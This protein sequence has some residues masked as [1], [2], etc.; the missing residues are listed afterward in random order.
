VTPRIAYLADG[1]VH[2]KL[3][4]EPPRVVESPFIE[5]ARRRETSIVQ[6]NAW[7][8][9]GASALVAARGADPTGIVDLATIT[10]ISRGRAAEELLYV[11]RT[12]AVTGLFAFDTTTGEEQRLF[13]GN[14]VRV[15]SA[16]IRPGVDLVACTLRQDVVGSHIGVMRADGSA[17]TELTDGDVVDGSPSW[18]SDGPRRLLYQSAGVARDAAGRVVGVGPAAI[19]E[20][21]LERREVRTLAESPA[22]DLLSPRMSDDGVLYYIRR[23]WSAGARLSPLRLLLNLLLLP[24]RLL[25]AIFQWLNFFTV[26]YSGRP[27]IDSPG[28]QQRQLDAR[29]WFMWSNLMNAAGQANVDPAARDVDAAAPST[30]HLVRQS[31]GREPEVIARGICAFDLTADG[32][33]YSTGSAVH[34]RTPDGTDVRVCTGSRIGQV[35]ALS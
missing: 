34:H 23:P 32:V 12:S 18:T 9:E 4:D 2:V 16:S 17:L 27:L 21:D 5:S 26:R 28:A 30:W 8:T 15:E 1:K 3:G 22:H 33:V 6:R 31:A 10:G 19:Q 25:A 14:Q 11:V 29:Q 13:H 7:K 35:V 20:L 24:F